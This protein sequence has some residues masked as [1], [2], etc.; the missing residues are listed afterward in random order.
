MGLESMKSR[1]REHQTSEAVIREILLE[2]WDPLSVGD[3]PSLSDEYDV[4]YLGLS[5]F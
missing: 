1:K 4:L 5:E 3:N 2:Q